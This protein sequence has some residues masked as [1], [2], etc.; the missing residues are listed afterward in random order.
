MLFRKE[1][2]EHATNRLSGEVILASSLSFKIMAG[3]LVFFISILALFLSTATY[4][5]KET[6]VGWLVPQGGLIRVQARNGG[7]LEKLVVKEGDAVRAGQALA[8]IRLSNAVRGGDAG[9]KLAA[10]LAS[11][12]Q[13]AQ[14][15]TQATRQKLLA[16]QRDLQPK[17]AL[18][19]SQ[20]D[21]TKQQIAFQVQQVEVAQTDFDALQGL[22]SDGLVTRHEFNS[23]QADLISAQEMLARLRSDSLTVQQQIDDIDAR[24]HAIPADLAS[25]SAQAASASASIS[26]K[27]TEN[28]AQ[29]LYIATASVAGR[30]LAIPVEQGQTLAIGATVAVLT[31]KGSG[32]E[33]ELYAPSRAAG[34]VKAGEEVRLMY[35]AF[36]YDKFG[37]ARGTVT[38]ISR[39]ILAPSEISI[40]GLNLSQPVF[41][42]R[43]K[44]PVQTVHAYGQNIPLQPGMLLSAD[45]VFDRRSLVQWLLDPLYAAGRRA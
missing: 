32:L 41:R 9:E 11:E 23:R 24:L 40:P 45:I 25:A 44:L 7:V 22:R 39:T 36:P 13:A 18:L 42:V 29:S 14:A 31:P 3:L 43:V 20:L 6:V 28:E 12:T 21:Q 30:V 35:E 38:T 19:A 33:V 34:F 37:T 1:A 17:R 5:R 4:A 2:I 15:Q 16:E 27:G 8:V 10:D 26:E